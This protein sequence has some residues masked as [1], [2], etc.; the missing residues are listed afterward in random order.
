MDKQ[1]ESKEENGKLSLYGGSS[2]N[3][4]P[5]YEDCNLAAGVGI[6]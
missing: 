1:V 2:L 6:L 4:K 3:P 5:Y